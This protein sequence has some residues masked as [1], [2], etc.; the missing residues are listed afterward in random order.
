VGFENGG[1]YGAS[2]FALV[3]LS[4]S[5]CRELAPHGIKVT[6]LCPAWTDTQMA[7]QSGSPL[8]AEEMLQPDD[9]LK[10]LRW[11]MSLSPAACV[12]EVVLEVRKQLS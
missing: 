12:P 11:L 1:A 8:A 2:K 7:Y 5:L 9:L 6:A 3:G 10:T 4:E